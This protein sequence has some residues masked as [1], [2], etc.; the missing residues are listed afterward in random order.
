M[1]RLAQEHVPNRELRRIHTEQKMKNWIEDAAGVFS[2]AQ[3][4]GFNGDHRQPNG[5]RQPDLDDSLGRGSQ[6]LRF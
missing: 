2:R 4:G 3:I 6:L 1:S 5:G